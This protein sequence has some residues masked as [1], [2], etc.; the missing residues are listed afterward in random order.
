MNLNFTNSAAIKRLEAEVNQRLSHGHIN[1]AL[2]LINRFVENFFNSSI[3]E[4]SILSSREI[5][6]LCLKIGRQNLMGLEWQKNSQFKSG[7]LRPKIIYI[8][9]RLQRSGGHSRLILDFIRAQP[10]CD[11]LIVS[12]RVGGRTDDEFISQISL[13]GER[14]NI[15]FAPRGNLQSRLSWLQN[16]L[17]SHMPNHVHLFNNHNDSVAVSAMVPEIF[18]KGSFHHHGDHHLCLGVHFDHLDHIDFHPGGYHFCRNVLGINNRYLPLTIED[19]PIFS[20]ERRNRGGLALT[21]ATVARSNKI[22]IPYHVN[23]LD[24]IPEVLKKT[25]GRHIHI[26]RLSPLALYRI[27]REM[28]KRGISRDRLVYIGWSKNVWKSLIELGV[29]VYVAS[30]PFG[31]G[32]TLVEVMGAGIPIILH[33]HS[34]SRVLGGDGL[35]Y[36]EA[37]RWTNPEALIN[38]LANLDV[39][40]LKSESRLSRL[41]YEHFHKFEILRSYFQDPQSFKIDTPLLPMKLIPAFHELDVNPECVGFNFFHTIYCRLRGI[42]NF[43]NTHL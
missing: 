31:G 23:Y 6:S 20:Y 42:R 34:F 16:M 13:I 26:G 35:V 12:T 21:T 4:S 38:H 28:R 24:V 2:L 15:L 37:F 9:S 7:N 10:E 43:F 17:L 1:S 25:G 3:Y 30:F 11:H 39:E 22:E 29:D 14:A 27:R 5:D 33:Q 41:R 19:Q 18:V 36:P 40:R 8:V 32:L